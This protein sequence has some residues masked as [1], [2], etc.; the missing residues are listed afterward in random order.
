MYVYV[1]VYIYIYIYI[2][3]YD[4]CKNAYMTTHVYLNIYK[5]LYIFN[6]MDVIYIKKL[7]YIYLLLYHS[8]IT[9]IE[10]SPELYHIWSA[11]NPINQ[12]VTTIYY[13]NINIL[14]TIY[15]FFF[16]TL[17]SSLIHTLLYINILLC[18]CEREMKKIV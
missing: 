15:T 7:I 2:Y 1:C 14:I 18:V 3:I 13:C 16:F 4:M 11:T 9:D 12:I 17:L 5:F 10:H 6:S 8:S